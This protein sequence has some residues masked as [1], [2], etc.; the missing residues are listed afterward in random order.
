MEKRIE[1]IPLAEIGSGNAKIT[2]NSIQIEV[3]GING[4]LKAWLIGNE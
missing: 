4:G 2:E 3:S 1:L